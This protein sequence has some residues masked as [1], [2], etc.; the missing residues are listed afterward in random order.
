MNA[1]S[2]RIKSWRADPVQMVRDVFGAEPDLWQAEALMAFASNDPIK[3]RIAMQACAGPG[4]ST[5]L[6]WCA[7]N[8]LVCYADRSRHPNGA[9]VS[10]TG[11]NL[12][13]GLW[14]EL[15]VWRSRAPFLQREF[16]MTSERISS[17]EHPKT[18]YFAARSYS[19]AADADAQGRTLS[20]LHAP[21]I[22]YL[23]DE[24]GDMNPA[25]L[26]SAE[27]GLGNCE[28]GKIVMAGN[29]TSQNGALYLAASSQRHLWHLI[30]ITADPDAENR[31][32]RVSKEWAQQQID[33]YGRENPWVMAYILGKYPP[34]GL[35]TLLTA[36][37]VNGA[38]GKHLREDE[39]ATSQKRLGIDVARFGDDRTVIFPRQG[40]AA[41][42]PVEMRNARTNEIAARVAT[43][44]A[45]WG[46]EMEFIDATGGWAGGVEDQCLL[47]GFPLHAVQFGGKPTDPRYFNKRSELHF[48]AA[49]WVKRGGALPNLPELTREATAPTYWFDKGKLRV[50]EKDQIKQRLGNS[51]DLWDALITT[52]AIPD[53]PA[54]V[55]ELFGMK[56]PQ[57]HAVTE[58]DPFAMAS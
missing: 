43:A 32:P 37:E 36:D 50:E 55:H 13:N 3:R 20:G 5:V 39:Y 14:K 38:L 8:F 4:K 35:N 53:M 47:A 42:M 7:W 22:L 23:L 46:S 30:S 16:D 19:K 58:Y 10:I 54:N 2:A 27:Q 17:R 12:Q 25:V 18:W 29:T 21:F 1:A 15:A 49:E 24:T 57:A 11:E 45:R 41:F 26:R 6:A 52:F 44:K 31:T 34:G 28:W 48:L 40:L 33:L 9:A 56:R 51:P